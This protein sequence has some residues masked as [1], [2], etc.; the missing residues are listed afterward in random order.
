[1]T[2]VTTCDKGMSLVSLHVTNMTTPWT[3]RHLGHYGKVSCQQL[4]KGVNQYI[5]YIL[6]GTCSPLLSNAGQCDNF[7]LEKQCIYVYNVCLQMPVGA[8]CGCD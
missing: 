5:L 8:V 3:F 2:S 7:G 4:G 1:M 6:L